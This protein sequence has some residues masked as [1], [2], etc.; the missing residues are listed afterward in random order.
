[1]AK[2][3]YRF[4]QKHCDIWD[5][6][7]L[8]NDANLLGG[9][10]F[11]LVQ[12]C[13]IGLPVPPGFTITT[14]VCNHYRKSTAKDT[15]LQDLLENDSGNAYESVLHCMEWLREQFGYMPLV[16]VRSG[17]PVSMPGM[18]D[19]I[20]NVG[21]TSETFPEWS[22][23]IGEKPALDSYRRLIQMLGSTAFGID[24]DKF[25]FQLASV[26]KQAAVKS[27]T[28]LSK[29]NLQDLIKRYKIVFKENA[30]T[31]FP[32]SMEMQLGFAIRAVFDSWMNPR[33]IEYRKLTK[34]CED[35]GTAVNVQA[36]VFGNMGEDSGSGVLFSRDP[37]TGEPKIM[38][39][40]LRN[41]QGEDVV[42]GIRTP[43][44]LDT[45]EAT[46]CSELEQMTFK[47]E[48]HYK[49]MVDIEFTVQQGKLFI[50][51]SRVGK[52]SAMAA[53]KI[54][55]DLVQ[56][57]VV[58]RDK[59][60]ARLTTEQFKMVRRPSIDPSFKTKPHAVGLPACPGVAKGKPVFSAKD[61]INCTEPCILVTH[62]TTPDDIAGMAKAVGI[63]TQT[64]GATSHAAVVARAMDK[65][66]VVG[67][68]ELD[69]SP[70]K[71]VNVHRLTIDGGTGRVWTGIDVPV[72]DSSDA[73]EIRAIMDW[74]MERMGWVEPSVLDR[75]DDR[76]HRIIAAHW[77]G[78]ADVLEAVLDGLAAKDKL[79][80]IAIDFLPPKKR[81]SADDLLLE[82]CFV[83]GPQA[84]DQFETKVFSGLLG[85][86]DLKGLVV[87]NCPGGPA[88]H[89][90]LR[91][92][93][94]VIP[95]RPKTVADLM[96][97]AV[98]EPDQEFIENVIG[99]SDA[100]S[101]IRE[102]LKTAGFDMTTVP[103][104]APAEYAVFTVLG[105]K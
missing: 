34:L 85:R 86:D 73:H 100:W 64:G 25:E 54:A 92:K 15:L 57:G 16:S 98:G 102:A 12:M 37:S 48:Q 83:D 47:L 90:L 10:G 97:A 68:T 87:L 3:I 24:H 51:Q 39:E 60:L 7:E 23:R 32:D 65:P 93:G 101:K 70:E 49:D 22:Q 55:H 18:M 1:M 76:P 6:T 77:W 17:A 56:E 29:K 5:E 99:G 103:M 74:C 2:R 94:Y 84:D 105:A 40:Y 52:R 89:Q 30:G 14:A 26:K 62:E 79:D 80:G 59:A 21:L 78:D 81:L 72:V 9:K 42:A 4:S 53:F 28:E 44:K 33:A 50:L 8:G 20:L 46:W 69:L 67:C 11:G 104:A 43:D 63:L 41:A 75:D 45:V 71:W 82:G 61:A 36:M 31:D 38:G 13:G 66:C 96:Q 27:D 88:Q 19:T 35:M 58:T 91:K 95:T